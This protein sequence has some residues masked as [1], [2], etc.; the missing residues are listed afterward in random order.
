MGIADHTLQRSTIAYMLV[1][2]LLVGGW[3]SHQGMGRFED[4]EFVIRDAVVTTPYVGATAQ[5]VADEVTDR[6]EAAIQQMQEVKE[7][8][9]VSRPGRSE[10]T[11][12]IEM[13][14]APS[15]GDLE[16][17][18]D[19][20][21]RKVA[22]A[23]RQL[24]PGAGPSV[25]NDDFGDVF[26]LFMAVTGEGFTLAEIGAYVDVLA[27]D[28]RPVPGVARVETLG[29]AREA[30]FV[31][32]ARERAAHLG[33]PL[34]HVYAILQA[35]NVVTAAGDVAAGAL[36][37]PIVPAGGVISV[38]DIRSLVVG[39]GDGGVIRLSDVAD[40]RRGV[41]EP[42]TIL[43]RHNGHPA[44][45]LGVSN[46]S[47]GNVVAMGDS[48]R[49]RLADLESQRPIG[50]DIHAISWQSDS[51]RDAVDGF[52]EN[53]AAAIAIVV[54]VL[55]AFMGLRAALIIGAV[56]L[57]TVAGTL[58]VM[59][60]DGI[61]MHRISLGALI[62]ALGMLVD[63]AIV[64]ADGMLV[65]MKAGMPARAA[66][67]ES[68]R[69]TQWPLL[70]GTAV[71]IL[72]FSAIGFSPTSMGE[73]AGSLFWVIC[74][75]MLLSWVFAVTLTPLLCVH[76]LRAPAAAPGSQTERDDG[77]P[78]RLYRGLLEGA[79]RHVRITILVLIALLGLS[80]WGFGFVTPGF[81]PDS[82][83]PQFVVDVALA[84]GTDI[85]A[86]AERLSAMEARV[87]R[88][89]GVTAVS[90]F[91]GGGA[92]RFMLSY[93]PEPLN[94]AY[95]Q[96]LVDVDDHSRIPGLVADL[97]EEL[98]AD[99]PDAEIKV[100]KFMLGKG[101]GKKI[102][103]GFSGPDPA[104][105]RSLA[106]QAKA[107]FRAEPTLV[108]IQ[109]DWRA[110][111]ATLEPVFD[112]VAAQRAGI[113]LGDMNRAIN[114][115]YVGRQ[116]GVFREGDDQIP[117]IARAPAAE[118]TRPEDVGNVLVPSPTAGRSIPV[119]QITEGVRVVFN[120]AIVRRIDGVPTIKAQADPAP[121]VLTATAF[122]AVRSAV[123]AIPLPPG[124]RLVWFGEYKESTEANAGLALSAPYGLAAMVLSVVVM[125]NALRQPLLIWLTVPLA[126]V[127]VTVGLLLFRAP[128][129][130]MAILG[131]LSLTG[132]LVKN[133]IVLVDQADVDTRSGGDR[134]AALA[135][136]S[137]SR[138]RPVAL[139]AL[140][141]ILGVAPLLLD[142][143]FKSMAI[144]IMF[145][146]LFATVL[147]LVVIPVLYAAFFGIRPSAPDLNRKPRISR[148]A[149]A[150]VTS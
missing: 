11:V 9:S 19:K 46:V 73:Y 108:A 30:I 49:A 138:V 7:I 26:A 98:A 20:L 94:S 17:V 132:M 111:V 28:L 27:D 22:D 140:T 77:A 97:Q 4:P 54:G 8:R 6:I 32:V 127:G 102:E 57:L 37:I 51:V 68:V 99:F 47:G 137:I 120:D 79:V 114:D 135:N 112:A 119:F 63:N 15:K 96:L 86:T 104:I 115:A 117:I 100:W 29:K 71:G 31:E 103:A 84:Q 43:V 42:P 113:T 149:D 12:S 53:L 1:V 66:A 82:A 118:R 81:M 87:A 144:T 130:F 124:Y 106:D 56:L 143:F 72:A 126:L 45:A 14:F 69:T 80:V 89:E 85:N 34:D 36:R 123:E 70:G 134:F 39:S 145:G 74:Y 58:I 88:R 40:I 52:V 67:A 5:Q 91:V 2:L 142:P 10:V 65:R 107:V 147:T 48:V 129:E 95:G 92:L 83:R 16:Q 78:T 25:V 146:L 133:A 38:E 136:A 60:F 24:P 90:S 139:G 125:F 148:V 35:Q 44:V 62:I 128:F 18:W 110:K 59:L 122:E 116:I 93:G 131:F 121:G 61:A 50:M 141:T 13:S 23:Q 33:I 101:G 41:I 150:S 105:L 55:L 109:D 64:V 75:S 21:R 76:F 3:L